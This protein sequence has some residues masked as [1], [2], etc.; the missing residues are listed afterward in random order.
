MDF[1]QLAVGSGSMATMSLAQDSL[2]FREGPLKLN[3]ILWNY[4]HDQTT[5]NYVFSRSWC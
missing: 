1:H 4:T 5:D 3:Q 2:W